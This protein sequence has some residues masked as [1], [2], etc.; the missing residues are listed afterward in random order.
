MEQRAL[1]D[2]HFWGQLLGLVLFGAHISRSRA[3]DCFQLSIFLLLD[4]LRGLIIPR[5]ILIHKLAGLCNSEQIS[6]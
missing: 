1:W 3:F 2:G 6:F 5:R 4:L